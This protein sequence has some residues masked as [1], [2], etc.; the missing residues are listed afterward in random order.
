MSPLHPNLLEEIYYDKFL[1]IHFKCWVWLKQV[2]AYDPYLRDRGAPPYRRGYYLGE[3]QEPVY[4]ISDFTFRFP[5]CEDRHLQQKSIYYV[6]WLYRDTFNSP[7]FKIVDAGR[8]FPSVSV[9]VR[10]PVDG[11][12]KYGNLK[13]ALW[14][15]LVEVSQADGEVFDQYYWDSFWQNKRNLLIGPLSLCDHDEQSPFTFKSRHP[16]GSYMTVGIP[17]YQGNDYALDHAVYLTSSSRTMLTHP[18]KAVQL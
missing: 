16:N 4:D 6:D 1:P 12:T 2:I 8:E 15:A 11:K 10:D 7:Y 5:W 14:G 3:V 9:E 17:S 18:A 13:N